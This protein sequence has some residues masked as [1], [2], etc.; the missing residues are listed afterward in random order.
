MIEKFLPQDWELQPKNQ[1]TLSH[2][3]TVAAA[4][5]LIA[6]HTSKLDPERAYTYGLMHDIGK[7]YLSPEES[8]KH[9]RVGYELLI[10]AYPDIANICITHPFPNFESYDHILKYHH[11]DEKEARRVFGILQTAIRDDY[12]DLIQLCD[13]LSRLCDYISWEEKLAWYVKNYD[14]PSDEIVSQYGS[15]LTRIKQKFDEMVNGD[16]YQILKITA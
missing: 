1:K 10:E 9:P 11:G 14:L 7:F 3:K 8:Y 15:Q 16:I 5:K 2:S 13:K 4:A 12:V 6:Q